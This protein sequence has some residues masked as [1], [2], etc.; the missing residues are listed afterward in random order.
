MSAQPADHDGWLMCDGRILLRTQYQEL[1]NIIGTQFGAPTAHTFRLPDCRGRVPA[2]IGDSVGTDHEMGESIGNEVIA[3]TTDELPTHDHSVTVS[4]DGSHTHTG[5]RT[6]SS[7]GAHTHTLS[8][9]SGGS[10]SH[11]FMLSKDDGNSSHTS[12]QYP[13][14][15]AAYGEN[16]YFVTTESGGSHTHSGTA[17]SNGDHTHTVTI[18]SDGSHTHTVDVLNTG[19]GEEFSLMQPTLFIG[20]L[21]IYW[22]DM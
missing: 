19:L 20:N 17:T 22:K 12:N 7:D 13:A 21:F 18:P 4:T 15:D 8:I 2:M 14:G 10:H 3:L 1:F 16:G 6:T 11:N 9:N 5:T